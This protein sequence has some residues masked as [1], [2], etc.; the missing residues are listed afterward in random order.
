MKYQI[1][2]MKL[3]DIDAII[4]GE[5][6]VFQETLG[7]DMFY[8]ELTLNPYAFYFVLDIDAQVRGY[9][10]LWI[11]SERSEIVNFYIEK[12]YQHQGYGSMIL[13]FAINLSVMSKVPMMSL[14]VRESNLEAISLYE[15]YGFKF[16]YRREKYYKDLED[17]LV[18]IKDLR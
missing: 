1:R 9:I 8:S 2:E 7:Y 5:K 3:D 6:R 4:E 12:E 13:E 15:K 18:M 17:A 16:A 10:G 14:E 11:E